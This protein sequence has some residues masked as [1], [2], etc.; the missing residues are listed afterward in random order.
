[1]LVYERT[2]WGWLGWSVP[3]D[4]TL[5]Q[6]PSQIGVITPGATLKQRL[7]VRWLTRRPAHRI[8]LT[9]TGPA[10]LRYSAAAVGALSLLAALFALRRGMPADLVLPAMLLAPL[11]TEHL[12]DRLDDRARAHVRSTEEDAACQYLHGLAALHTY[13]VEAA[14]GSNVYELRRSAEISRNLLWGAA[15]LLQHQDTCT[16]TA[17]L[18]DLG[19]LMD[20][21]AHQVAQTL[22]RT[23]AEP[24][25]GYAEWRCGGDGPVVPPFQ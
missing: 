19:R 12:P 5:P 2:D 23:R 22:E 17:R 13:I 8:A 11:L 18:T 21:L 10:S 20:Q 1:M 9:P 16:A 4:G 3:G 6:R 7:A 14:N 25:C 15:D 24:A